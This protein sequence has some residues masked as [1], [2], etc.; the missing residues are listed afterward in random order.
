MTI[1]ESARQQIKPRTRRARAWNEK[2]PTEKHGEGKGDEIPRTI[3]FDWENGP[4]AT[5]RD[6]I[7]SD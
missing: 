6:L 3:I 2:N 4:M 7:S 1:D 5:D